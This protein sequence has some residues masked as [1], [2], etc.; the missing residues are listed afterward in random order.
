MKK[1][2]STFLQRVALGVVCALIFSY[3]VYHLIGL[4]GSEL[5]TFAAGATTETTSLYYNGYVFRDETVLTSGYDGVADYHVKDGTKVTKGQHLA[6][7]YEGGTVTRQNEL[8]RID[9]QIAVLEKSTGESLKG[10]DIGEVKASVSETYGMLVNMLASGDTGGLSHRADRLLVYMNQLNEL[11]AG[12]SGEDPDFVS[13]EQTLAV[14]RETRTQLLC[15]GGASQEHLAEKSGYFYRETDGYES[16]FTMDAARNLSVKSFA[17]LTSEETAAS[18]TEQKGAYG[19][20][21]TNTEWM[22]VLSAKLTEK[23]YFEIDETYLGYFDENNRAEIP[24]TLVNAVED[25]SN[26]RILLVFLADRMPEHFTFSRTQSVRIEVD[27]VSGIYVPKNVIQ[28]VDGYRGVYILRGNVVYFRYIEIVYEGRDYYL[29][30]QGVESE[31]KYAY[32]QVNDLII[33]NG[34]NLFDGRVLD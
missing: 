32:L 22:L 4:F 16:R 34:K 14:L 7:V 13:G 17:R 33:L 31:E 30:K 6:T 3:T 28:R 29:V 8:D 9:E 26:G 10:L 5:S 12:A 1:L 15:E 2:G 24:L 27:S 19:K 23:A 11:T 20:L 18:A 25:E 21:C